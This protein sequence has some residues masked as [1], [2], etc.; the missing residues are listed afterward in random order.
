V[1]GVLKERLSAIIQNGEEWCGVTFDIH[2]KEVSDVVFFAE[3]TFEKAK[4]RVGAGTFGLALDNSSVFLFDLSFPFSGKSKI[5]LVLQNELE[6]VIPVSGE[7]MQIDFTE[8]G[9]GKILA[10]GV[11]RATIRDLDL[12]KQTKVLTVQALGALHAL[13]WL[14]N[15]DIAD[16]VLIHTS[17]SA[18]V[19]MAFKEG[20][21]YHLRQFFHSAASDSLDD[22]LS[23]IIKDSTYSPKS[24]VTIGGAEFMENEASRLR[25]KFHIQI[26]SPSLSEIIPHGEIPDWGWAAIGTGLLSKRPKGSINLLER[27]RSF[28]PFSSKIPLYASASLAVIGIILAGL[29]YLNYALKMRTF[30]YLLTEPPKVYRASFPKSPPVKDPIAAFRDR[31]KG[32]D[33]QPGP[34]GTGMNPLAILNEI[35]IRVPA[36]LD[37]KVDEFV[38]DEKDFTISGTTVSFAAAEKI[39]TAIEQIRGVSQVEPQ[40][41]ELTGAKQVKFKLRGKL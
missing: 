40:N 4:T 13:R 20:H 17:G 25:E 41:L 23:S 21:L 27:T 28:L 6:Q 16:F 2:E 22:A 39:K 33:K 32:L 37:V 11:Q 8:N 19:L 9:N 31:I 26:Y 12:G 29:S 15:V 5:R 1:E 35:S 7:D 36:D 34:Q 18:V 10:A 38:V 30:Q 14:G 24:F 3:D